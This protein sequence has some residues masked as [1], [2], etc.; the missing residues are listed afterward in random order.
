VDENPAASDDE[1]DLGMPVAE[2]KL[3]DE[4][5]PAGFLAGVRRSVLRRVGAVDALDFGVPMLGRFLESMLALI[6]GVFGGD[7]PPRK[8]KDDA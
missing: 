6:F 8:G 3:L 5:P 4:P 7:S 1:T 2:L